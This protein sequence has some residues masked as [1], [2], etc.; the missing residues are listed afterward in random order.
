MTVSAE[1]SDVKWHV[2]LLWYRRCR[3]RRVSGV[4]LFASLWLKKQL[5][6]RWVVVQF[7][8]FNILFKSRTPNAYHLCRVLADT[9]SMGLT[10][11]SI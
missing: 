3:C 1:G 7:S 2:S 6:Q 11:Q 5:S 8:E 4:I 9:S 10:R